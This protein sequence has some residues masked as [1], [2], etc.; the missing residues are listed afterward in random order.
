MMTYGLYLI[1]DGGKEMVLAG[2]FRYR[3]EA[4][5][6]MRKLSQDEEKIQ[7]QAKGK[8]VTCLEV[9]DHDNY[10]TMDYIPV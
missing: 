1:I 3:K 2:L 5:D 9:I 6:A 7:L 8:D 4:L 10:T